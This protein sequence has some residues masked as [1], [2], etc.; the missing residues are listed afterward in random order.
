[1]KLTETPYAIGIGSSTSKTIASFEQTSAISYPSP[2][3]IQYPLTKI[4]DPSGYKDVLADIFANVCTS[5]PSNSIQKLYSAR[6]CLA[7]VAITPAT[8]SCPFQLIVLV[9]STQTYSSS[10]SSMRVPV[11]GQQ[12]CAGNSTR[13]SERYRVF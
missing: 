9:C 4:L 1:M 12:I 5:V 10:S 8:S 6:K 13:L 2:R 11:I 3:A 7:I